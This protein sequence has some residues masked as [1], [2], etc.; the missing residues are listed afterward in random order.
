[1][2]GGEKL[3]EDFWVLPMSDLIGLSFLEMWKPRERACLGV[4]LGLG[5]I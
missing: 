1:M 3:K 2:R 4:G 5:G